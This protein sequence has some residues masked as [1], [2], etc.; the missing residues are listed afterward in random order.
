MLK[1]DPS[2]PVMIA[3]PL[4]DS[5]YFHLISNICDHIEWEKKKRKVWYKD[6]QRMVD[7]PYYCLCIIYEYNYAMDAVDNGNQLRNT[8]C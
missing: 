3:P 6:L 1:G 8:Y 2:L 4:Y 7:M 5:K